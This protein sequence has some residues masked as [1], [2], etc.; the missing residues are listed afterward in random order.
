MMMSGAFAGPTAAETPVPPAQSC[1]QLVET[2][3]SDGRVALDGVTF[4]F[5]RASLRPDSMPAM[6][7]ARDAILT[8]GGSWAIEGHTDNVGNRDY[9]Q[10]LSEARATAVRDWLVAAGVA[11]D[12]LSA[13]GFSL[14]RPVA[15]NSTEAGRALN[16]RVELVGS[17]TPDMLGFG[18]PDGVNPCPDTLTPGTHAVMDDTTDLPDASLDAPESA[19]IVSAVPVGWTGPARNGDYITVVAPDAG[20]GEWTAY[21]MIEADKPDILLPMPAGPGDYVL[22]YI[23]TEG[24]AFPAVLAERPITVTESEFTLEAPLTVGRGAQFSVTW[25]GPANDSDYIDIARAD[26]TDPTGYIVWRPVGDGNPLSIDAPGE[27]GRYQLRYIVSGAADAAVGLSVPLEVV[28][29]EVFLVAPDAVQPGQ[30]TPVEV[31][32]PSGRSDWV[33]FAVRGETDPNAYLGWTSVSAAA[34]GVIVVTAP[35]AP[36]EYDLRYVLDAAITGREVIATRSITVS[37]DA[38]VAVPPMAGDVTLSFPMVVAPGESVPVTYTG[39]LNAGDWIDII[40]Q[41]DDANMS[42]GWSWAYVAD[43]Q[44]VLTAPPEEGEYTL[45][46]VADDPQLGRVVLASDVLVVRAEPAPTVDPTDIFY[47]CDGVGL[48]PCDLVLPEY[49]IAMTLLPG[50]G[51]TEPLV[52]VT[53][54]GATAERPSFDVVRMADGEVVVTINARQAQAV[55][56]QDGLAGD[57]MCVTDRVTDADGVAVAF[58]LAS[59]GSAAMALEMEAMGED[60]SGIAPGDLQGVWFARLNTPGQPDHEESFMMAELFQDAGEPEVFGYFITAPEVGPARGLIGDITGRLDGD[61]LSLTLADSDGT[62]LLQFTGAASGDIDFF[63]DV[64]PVD[65]DSVAARLSR[66]AGPGEEW[67]GPPWMTGN[68]SGMDAAMQMGQAAMTEMMVDLNE[69]DRAVVEIMGALMGTVANTATPQQ[70]TSS[71]NLTGLGAKPVDLQGMPAAAVIELIVPF[72]EVTP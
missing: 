67:S 69:E 33:D 53:P 9:N 42:G 72:Q 32:G 15:D 8:L 71:P 14:D 58:V 49:D 22:R 1:L 47:R 6:I 11:E 45:R 24:R 23:T 50:Y 10:T 27:I 20:P 40:T 59:L 25:T 19:P 30:L 18:G 63:G 21:V 65:G 39:P 57:T 13:Q 38:P 34:N 68:A 29:P 31:I 66:V 55:Y 64:A 3:A 4:E 16:R 41:G 62:P 28:E 35:E 12:Q 36:G 2:L 46:Y 70:G 60:E 37:V 48:T 5:N 54:A 44:V 43:T 56:C 61:T 51:L 7:A 52:Y 26:V 17:V